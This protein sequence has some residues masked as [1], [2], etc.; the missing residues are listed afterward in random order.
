[1]NPDWYIPSET[2]EYD[3]TPVFEKTAVLRKHHDGLEKIVMD[4]AQSIKKLETAMLLR[5]TKKVEKVIAKINELNQRLYDNK[6]YQV[7]L[8]HMVR[9]NFALLQK[10][11]GEIQREKDL[12]HKAEL[13]VKHFGSYIHACQLAV[14]DTEIFYRI[15]IDSI[16]KKE[17]ECLQSTV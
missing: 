2:D 6:Y 12:F 5:H 15:F 7:I 10:E 11:L 8:Q 4:N 14:R 13:I 3:L 16:E 1:V 17:A 9:F